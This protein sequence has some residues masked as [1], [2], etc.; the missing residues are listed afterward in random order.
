[1]AHNNA[2]TLP[3][4]CS[5]ATSLESSSVESTETPLGGRMSSI[6]P[7]S[8]SHAT[9]PLQTHPTPAV[10]RLRQQPHSTGSRNSTASV[11][12]SWVVPTNR[13]SAPTAAP[14]V[15][16]VITLNHHRPSVSRHDGSTA[17]TSSTASITY[18][19]SSGHHSSAT[20]GT[21]TSSIH[22]T[23]SS[24]YSNSTYNQS[25]QRRNAPRGTLRTRLRMIHGNSSAPNIHQPPSTPIE[26]NSTTASS[27]T[28]DHQQ[29]ALP[30]GAL[31]L[32]SQPPNGASLS[33]NENSS[34][35]PSFPP[36]SS[37]PLHIVMH[38]ALPQT[39]SI[40]TDEPTNTSNNT[41]CQS[42]SLSAECSFALGVEHSS[43]ETTATP[44]T[45]TAAAVSNSE[46]AARHSSMP[47]PRPGWRLYDLPDLHEDEVLDDTEGYGY[48][49]EG[50]HHFVYNAS[51]AS[52]VTNLSHPHQPSSRTHS[53]Q[54]SS[55]TFF[56]ITPANL[57]ALDLS[58]PSFSSSSSSYPLSDEI[59]SSTPL[60]PSSSQPYL[61]NT[62]SPPLPASS[63]IPAPTTTTT[64]N[65]MGPAAP[66]LPR[67]LKNPLA[68]RRSSTITHSIASSPSNTLLSPTSLNKTSLNASLAA[69]PTK[70]LTEE[71]QRLVLE[72]LTTERTYVDGL[73]VLQHL[74]YEPLNAPHAHMVN[75]HHS[76]TVTSQKV[77][78]STH[79]TLASNPDSHD[80]VYNTSTTGT[81]PGT[82]YSSL[83]NT[84]V[85]SL[86]G[87]NGGGTISST[88]TTANAN[89]MPPLLS[90]KSISE[91]FS[92]FA[93]ILRVNTV[94][95]TQLEKRICG[96]TFST[97]WESDEEEKEPNG[98]ESGGGA[99]EG[100][101]L[102]Q[103]QVIV[104]VGTQ[105]GET[106]HIVVLD[107]DWCI[108]DIFVEIA[109]FLKMYSSYV[110]TYA[111]ALTHINDCMK[112]NDRFAE[113]VKTR[114][115]RPEC[116]NLDFQS[117]LMKPV[118]RIPRYR[119][120]LE[121]LLRH[122]PSHHPDY[123]NLKQAYG[124]LEHTAMFVN[125]TI[126]QHEMFQ[127]M[128]DIQRRL[129]GLNEPL[130][131]PSR[132]LLKKGPVNKISR[133][134]VQ[135]RII[136]LFSDCL[137]WTSPSLN[138]IDDTLMC[139]RKV[140]LDNCTIV[141][142]DDP[143]PAKFAFQIISPDKSSQ[144]YVNSQKEKED[145][146]N[147]I[148]NATQEY[149][150][151][152][153]T[154][155]VS[156][157]PMH[158]I[159]AGT[160]SILAAG[161]RRYDSIIGG[162][163]GGNGGNSG[164]GRSQTMPTENGPE[165]GGRYVANR[166]NQHDKRNT[167]FQPVRVVEN[168]SAP[169]WV[170]D[171]SASRC[172]ICNQ[173][174]GAFF[175]RKHHCRACGKVTILIKSGNTDQGKV[176]RACDDCIAMLPEDASST[177]SD[178]RPADKKMNVDMAAAA[179]PSP[180]SPASMISFS[181][182]TSDTK[183]GSQGIG[184]IAA[185]GEDSSTD[186]ACSSSTGTSGVVQG[187]M[188][189]RTGNFAS[190]QTE[191]GPQSPEMASPESIKE[192][193]RRSGTAEFISQVKECA[194]CRDEFGYFKRKNVCQQCRRVVCSN[195]LTKKQLDQYFN[196]LHYA[197]QE[198]EELQ[199]PQQAKSDLSTAIS[200]SASPL[201]STMTVYPP[202]PASVPMSGRSQ[203]FNSFGSNGWRSLRNGNVD[204]GIGII[205]KLCDPCYLGLSMDQ[206]T[207]LEGG[208][209][210]QY[211]QA[212]TLGK[213]RSQEVAALVRAMGDGDADDRS[214]DEN[215]E[216]Q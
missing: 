54:N 193:K 46:K 176:S 182:D 155:K 166:P 194:L 152:K 111:S 24:T 137:I 116:K 100:E 192:A 162:G 49:D 41:D 25:Q 8:A 190:Q 74:F 161:L 179:L 17:S 167:Y 68:L 91:I 124:A 184:A 107:E 120:L 121:S 69:R 75:S 83:A 130:I 9:S 134:N 187:L 177:N 122:T 73:L 1:M 18:S 31:P 13:A 139:H 186:Q 144:V 32:L 197:S 127:E 153:R 2:Q 101:R 185:R 131:T 215:D 26:G 80:Q 65:S 163:N 60:S 146:M 53:R 56:S 104:A 40:S 151:A 135:L 154:L 206:V 169:V 201:D 165:D 196:P 118:Q 140:K 76:N 28:V 156:T 209:G 7:A 126:R 202:S 51:N 63:A 86:I 44:T 210:W 98:E 148:R 150:S 21:N 33:T 59:L 208:G 88:T 34:T 85:T 87:N 214:D 67:S 205:E 160:S 99:G 14:D 109:P 79:N 136:Y 66:P 191:T 23:I 62:L 3:D 108:G 95:L 138:P 22:S 70:V 211:T 158:S 64:S 96:T 181:E 103:R 129:S 178:P 143:D 81:L 15:T 57:S 45:P 141:G 203:S 199:S 213:H 216:P 10:Q 35:A 159:S 174:F 77:S 147:A 200:D 30:S 212:A 112:T 48:V 29:P 12:Q 133:R 102:Y 11:R 173:E 164:V 113:F 42:S 172:M 19:H 52:S 78:Y 198:D 5:L 4:R 89:N 93:E 125:E 157:T 27:T 207:V 168:F 38:P 171:Q 149:L 58:S 43:L 123:Q 175:R 82:L 128:L 170:P 189:S 6:S 61:A 20:S 119:M 71:R 110:R 84:S 142:A 94:L 92:N 115:R 114:N 72:I 36:R 39:A 132:V 180:Q 37:F 145:W 105:G 16:S 183:H 204:S 55:T 47:L 117:F 90:K 50:P 97:G 195:C 106:E 188:K